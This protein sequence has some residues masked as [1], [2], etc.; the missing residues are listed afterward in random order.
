MGIWWS[1]RSAFAKPDI[2]FDVH[3]A[4]QK[5][6]A[7]RYRNWRWTKRIARKIGK[8]VHKK[9]FLKATV[10]RITWQTALIEYLYMLELYG[11]R[12]YVSRK[13]ERGVR[14]NGGRVYSCIAGGD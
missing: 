14:Y 12:L 7:P 11:C 5:L 6:H 2:A 8:I 13:V 3:S 9:S 1:K 10:T 4:I